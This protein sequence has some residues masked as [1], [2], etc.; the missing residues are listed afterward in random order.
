MKE[1]AIFSVAGVG[2]GIIGALMV[3]RFLSSE[4][5]GISPL[6]PATY[7]AAAIVMTL[8]TLLASYVPTRRAMH[9][10]PLVALRYE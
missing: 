1:G 5:Y 4:L 6:D 7:G 8:V 9:V 2:I 10:D 3:S